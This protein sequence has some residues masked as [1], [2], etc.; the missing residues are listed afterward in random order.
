MK[1]QGTK[2]GFPDVIIFDVPE[3]IEGIAGYLHNGIA[4]ELK[5]IKGGKVRENQL[6]WLRKLGSRDWITKVCYG[7]DEAI[8]FLEKIFEEV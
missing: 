3:E 1:K 6:K 2:A 8:D 5:R 7:A 4:I